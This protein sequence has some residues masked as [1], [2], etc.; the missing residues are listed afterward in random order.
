MV[1]EYGSFQCMD[2]MRKPSC[3]VPRRWASN[4]G[5]H[6]TVQRI[7]MSEPATES[8]GRGA[9]KRQTD[10]LRW[11]H[12]ITRKDAAGCMTIIP[13]E[14]G[15]GSDDFSDSARRGFTVDR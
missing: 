5:Q 4:C 10:P 11:K 15:T 6:I 9:W 1:T 14:D 13:A 12:L 3:A 7:A 8:L 2:N